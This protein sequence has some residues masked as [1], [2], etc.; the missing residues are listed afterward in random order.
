MKAAGETGPVVTLTC[1]GGERYAGSYY[2]D[3]WLAAEHLDIAP[4]L[5]GLTRRVD[6]GAR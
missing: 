5:E 4:A 3:E 2:D 6:T 1:D